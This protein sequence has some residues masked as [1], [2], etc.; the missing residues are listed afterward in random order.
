[1]FAVLLLHLAVGVGVML[2]GDRLG[3][4]AFLVAAIAPAV[5]LAWVI[6]QW[7]AV[8]DGRP[9]EESVTWVEGLNL[10]LDLRLD[11][12][13][14]TMVLLVSG[15][16]LLVCIYS[17]GYFSH[18]DAGQVRLAGLITL[19]AGAMLGVVLTDHL[20]ALFVA[21][22]LTSVTSYLLIGND[23][24]NPRARAAALQA[25]FITGAGGLALLLGLIILGQSA[26]TY[27]ISEMLVTPPS[28]TAMGAAVVCI[29]LGAFTKSAQAPFSSWLPAAMVAPTPVS[30]YLHSATMVKAGVYLVA[31][32]SPILAA[33]GQWRALVLVVGAA[34]MLIGGL[35][36]LRQHDLKLLLA[37]GT[38]SQLG[39]MM[40]L[41]G[42]G[43]YKIA[44]AG[45]VLLLA[46]GAF[47]AALFM[48][49]GI[50]DH[51]AGTRDIRRL[52]G[53]G[54]G[55]LPV[56]VMA[57]I[58]AASMAGFPPLL[59]F[60]AKEKALDTYL[61]YG[62]E[63]TGGTAVLV[64]LVVGS[65]LTF[66]YSA[67]YVLG[68]LGW[69]GD[70]PAA[71][72][73]RSAPA[74]ALVFWAPAAVLTV[75]TVVAGLAPALIDDL[76]V[77]A[78][79]AIDPVASPSTITLWGGFNT[80][81]VLSLVI[82][83]SGSV[84][85]WFRTDVERGQAWTHRWISKLPSGDE[86]F[87]A[88]LRSIDLTANRTTALVQSG[89]LPVYLLVILSTAAIVPLVP[90]LPEL[91]A[92]PTWIEDPIQVPL[93]AI[94][95]GGA[96]GAAL[97]K[98]RIAA[99][100]MLSAVGFAMAGL[101]EVPRRA[102]PGADPVRDRDAGH[103]ALRPG[104][105][106]PAV[107]LRRPGAGG[108]AAVALA[109]V[110][111][112]R[113]LDLRVRAR[114]QR[115]AHRRRPALDLRGDDRAGQTRR[116]GPQRGQRH[117]RRLPR[118]RHDGRDHRARRRRRRCGFART[119]R[120]ASPARRPGARRR[121]GGDDHVRRLLIV[122]VAVRV[123][124][125][126]I[127]V[128][129]LYFLFAGHNQP[130]G[131]FV[132]GLAAGAGISLRYVQGGVVAVRNT[133]PLRPSTILGGGLAIS[134]TTVIIPLLTGHNVLDHAKIE[135]DFPFLHHVKVTSALTFDVGVYLVVLGLVLMAFEAFG[136]DLDHEL[137][138][139][140]DPK[141]AASDPREEY[142]IGPRPPGTTWGDRR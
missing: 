118:L 99:A 81:V 42:T 52:G 122:D 36:A 97:V 121:G 29:L 54:A 131:G 38:V 139:V 6:P 117:P 62:G 133:F 77:A 108:A 58:G 111:R 63:F 92:L 19:F 11:A 85:T 53:F 91:D 20:L 98:R 137:D 107:A 48:L 75:V 23:D 71:V 67:R 30:T 56:K 9:V 22:E 51:Q 142:R 8:V 141:E 103:R 28:G 88:T 66:A 41:F 15:I 72:E 12:L 60:I 13:A 80:A 18:P 86:G 70:G 94:I 105:A 68:L 59:G 7:S 114:R 35:R 25:I 37:Y 134:L 57:V 100:V 87:V 16:G 136:E 1:M 65:I 69:F 76:V 43:E 21:W 104:A 61:E 126:A 73:S 47:K 83:G 78:T 96:L 112:R 90:M 24:R 3:K 138:E 14:L 79:I 128:L 135:G 119:G 49:V 127:L 84:L 120:P 116:R 129:S 34:T 106:V 26:G 74:P 10:S 17:V 31:R 39:F 115:G 33:T 55:W 95:L 32:M 89:S 125:P 64:V 101:Y 44:E 46:H 50:V 102:R 93:V 2:S 82:I 124:Y 113:R 132:G 140:E 109:G 45:V 130:G 110:G 40:L 27:R 4:R 5:T 123:L